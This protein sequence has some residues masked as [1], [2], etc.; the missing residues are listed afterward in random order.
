MATQ[1]KSKPLLIDEDTISFEKDLHL[2]NYLIDQYGQ[3]IERAFA[4]LYVGNM[5]DEDLQDI[6]S[7]DLRRIKDKL[8]AHVRNEVK[9]KY[10]LQPA[11]DKANVIFSQLEEIADAAHNTV[12]HYA[13]SQ[14][15]L[16]S[17]N[18]KGK[19]V[20]TEV[21]KEELREYHRTYI[22]TEKGRKRYKAHLAAAKALQAFVNAMDGQVSPMDALDYFDVD[23]ADRLFPVT[24]YSY[25]K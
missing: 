19:I 24:L 1:E 9:S 15:E 7:N 16:I 5:T 4:R 10:F 25:E 22:T 21:S 8:M 20:L 18:D 3:S 14:I 23:E 12:Y 17:I 11:I 2:L 13:I 6:L